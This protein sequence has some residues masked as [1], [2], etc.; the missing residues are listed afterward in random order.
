MRQLNP[1][2]KTAEGWYTQGR[3]R[4][5]F[6]VIRAL[7]QA[8]YIDP[9]L[10]P[11]ISEH[12]DTTAYDMETP[13]QSTGNIIMENAASMFMNAALPLQSSFVKLKADPF[14]AQSQGGDPERQAR[15]NKGLM[16]YEQVLMNEVNSLN[17]RPIFHSALKQWYLGNVCFYFDWKTGDRKYFK[18]N[19]Y[20]VW[21]DGVGNLK[22]I[23][24]FER[25]SPDMLTRSVRDRVMRDRKKENYDEDVDVYTIVQR[26]HARPK[27]FTYQ[28]E[29]LGEIVEESV[30]SQLETEMPWMPMRYHW[31]SGEDYG[32]G[33]P[34]IYLGHMKSLEGFR[35][36]EL[37][38][39]AAQAKMIFLVDESMGLNVR[40]VIRSS[41]CAVLPG[42]EGAISVAQGSNVMNLQFAGQ[43]AERLERSC[44]R[45]GMLWEPRDSE[46]TPLGESQMTRYDM[47]PSRTGAFASLQAEFTNPF[48]T[49]VIKR[50]KSKKRWPSRIPVPGSEKDE[51]Q[52]IVPTLRTGLDIIGRNQEIE[53]FER[54]LAS[55]EAIHA[56]PLMQLY[57]AQGFESARAN[58]YGID[59]TMYAMKTDEEVRAERQQQTQMAMMDQRVPT[60][61]TRG[62]MN[63]VNKQIPEATQTQTQ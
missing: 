29:V 53:T 62:V 60:E 39:G 5:I 23:V 30:G 38:G 61:A 32:R 50:L 21:R 15:L 14:V 56:S 63:M 51:E 46:R 4:R 41:N 16:V 17:I 28:Q 42:R 9:H 35:M 59:P 2:E 45:Q 33:G 43:V 3:G 27:F 49:R 37:Q 1:G 13:F 18:I 25:M 44:N 24:T 47:D 58:L 54:Y 40:D 36:L 48:L 52:F 12:T 19:Q 10:F 34:E 7:D 57:H 31:I 8:K 6:Y 22:R 20:C 55:G 11:T 26:D